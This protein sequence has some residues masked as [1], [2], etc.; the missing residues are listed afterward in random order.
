MRVLDLFSG[1]GGFSLGLERAGLQTVAFCEQDEFCQKVL[2]KHWPSV[3]I[4]DDVR[5]INYDGRV[6]VVCGGDPCQGNSLVGERAGKEDARYFWPEMFAN[7]K[8]HRPIAV[9]RENVI[10]NISNSVLDEVESDLE[11]EGYTVR[12]F[13]LPSGAFGARHERNRTWTLAYAFGDRLQG[14]QKATPEGSIKRRAEQLAGFLQPCSWPTLSLA[15][16][17]RDY[18]GVSNRMDRLK[19]LGNSIT[20]QISEM[21]GYIILDA[22]GAYYD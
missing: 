5:T 2:K 19:S 17:Y 18:D 15:K 20:P 22:V 13:V 14:R 12:T 8:K 21:F 4:Y 16:S 10:G 6:D 1:I 3:P 11:A 7:V 9:L